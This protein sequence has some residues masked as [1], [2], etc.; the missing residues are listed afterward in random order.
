MHMDRQ[1]RNHAEG[2][3]HD[4]RGWAPS[5]GYIPKKGAHSPNHAAVVR[6]NATGRRPRASIA[7]RMRGSAATVRRHEPGAL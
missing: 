2:A 4:A 3:A 1:C 5:S 7:S 6:Y